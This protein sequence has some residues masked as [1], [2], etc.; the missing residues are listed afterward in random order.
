MICID[1]DKRRRR[2]LQ[3]VEDSKQEL[4]TKYDF[5]QGS[6]DTLLMEFEELDKN[7]NKPK[8]ESEKQALDEAN[9]EERSDSNFG[10]G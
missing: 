9:W 7:R 2:Y 1:E 3:D 4:M 10:A 8:D 6:I 5:N